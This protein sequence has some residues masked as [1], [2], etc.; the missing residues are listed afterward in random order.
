M[1]EKQRTPKQ[2][3]TA[4]MEGT[5]ERG[6]SHI[7]WTNGAEEGCKYENTKQASNGQRPSGL[8]EDCIPSQGPQRTVD[9]GEKE[10][11]EKG[12]RIKRNKEGRK[13]G[14]K[15]RRKENIQRNFRKI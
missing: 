15:E 12:K 5:R 7:R 11:D 4:T 8:E 10:E 13:E 14:R 6:R 9:L 2:T 1:Y 3:A